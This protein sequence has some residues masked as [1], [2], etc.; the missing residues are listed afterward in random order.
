ME[1]SFV[2]FTIEVRPWCLKDRVLFSVV[3]DTAI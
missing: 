1:Y 3:I 2:G